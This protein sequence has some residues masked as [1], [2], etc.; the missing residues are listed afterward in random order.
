MQLW[1]FCLSVIL[2]C[3]TISAFLHLWLLL[4]KTSTCDQRKKDCDNRHLGKMRMYKNL[5][6]ERS[7]WHPP[8]QHVE[9]Y[10]LVQTA[11]HFLWTKQHT[12]T[13][14]AGF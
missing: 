12:H 3:W 8:W 1:D 5:P 13:K 6:L 14:N 11:R 7:C 10:S 9:R 2:Q 4:H